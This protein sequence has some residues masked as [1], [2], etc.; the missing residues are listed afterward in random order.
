[1]NRADSEGGEEPGSLHGQ[2]L[3][4]VLEE[5]AD[6][7]ATVPRGD[8]G[9]ARKRLVA[10]QFTLEPGPWDG[11]ADTESLGLLVLEGLLTRDVCVAESCSRELLG[12]GDVI[13]PWDD[14]SALGSF[15]AQ[16]SWTVIEPTRLAVL[17]ARFT[18]LLG[19][20][21]ALAGEI[22]S[23]VLRRSRWLAIRLAIANTRGLADRI[24]LLFWHLAGNWG[25]VTSAGTLL[26]IDLTHE[27]I[28]D[29]I[30]ARRP[31]VTTAI[32]ELREEGR[33]ERDEE[34]WVLRGSGP[35]RAS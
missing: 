14:E 5:D 18:K 9:V 10:R 30:G 6:L 3:V 12:A 24:M 13:R 11:D 22:I 7:L 21:P 15:S 2:D 34:G 31:S 16:A 28:A 33:L 26:P 20:W 4:A 32:T 1:M 17:D 8:V 19:R 25:R 35:T 29:L 23:R 27:L